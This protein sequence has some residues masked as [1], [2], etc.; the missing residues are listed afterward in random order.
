[1]AHRFTADC[2]GCTACVRQCPTGAIAGE[3]RGLHQVIPDLCIDCGVCGMI[4]HVAAVEDQFGHIVDRIPRNRRP[5]PVLIADLCNG[6]GL[7]ID[8]CPYAC[9]SLVGRA[10]SGVAVLSEPLA[11]VSCG[12][13]AD[14]CIKGAMVMT[15]IDLRELDPDDERD[16]ATQILDAYT[17]AE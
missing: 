6:C 8:Y 9:L 2:D 5:R 1:M 3:L 17:E 13:C 16:R 12:E 11:C 15:P 4:C 10:H 7:C 14:V